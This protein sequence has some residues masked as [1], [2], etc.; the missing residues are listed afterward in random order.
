MLLLGKA[1]SDV[2]NS[3]IVCYCFKLCLC[4]SVIVGKQVVLSKLLKLSF[5][6]AVLTYSGIS[7]QILGAAEENEVDL[8][9]SFL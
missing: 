7:F 2:L 1:L 9:S 3:K 8:G 4:L 6:A 5:V